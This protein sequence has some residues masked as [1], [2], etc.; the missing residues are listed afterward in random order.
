MAYAVKIMKS[1]GAVGLA[2]AATLSS[3]CRKAPAPPPAI[4]PATAYAADLVAVTTRVNTYLAGHNPSNTPREEIRDTVG[5]LAAAYGR[6]GAAAGPLRGKTGDISY[7][8]VASRAEDGL[9]VAGN[10]AGA[11]GTDPASNAE[12]PAIL[13]GAINDWEAY[14]DE[15]AT[16]PAAKPDGYRPQ[17]WWLEPAW[18]DAATPT[19][20][21][22]P[23]DNV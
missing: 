17:R 16:L 1:F 15:L 21:R 4:K 8:V 20:N 12:A 6:I 13:A 5:T 7:G 22:Q 3:G 9:I 18:R 19:S 14:N 10:L 11:V 23:P 2:A